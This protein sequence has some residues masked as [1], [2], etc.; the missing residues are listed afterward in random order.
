M[1][2]PPLG[3]RDMWR[4]KKTKEELEEVALAMARTWP[5]GRDI[6]GVPIFIAGDDWFID[7][8]LRRGGRAQRIEEIERELELERELKAIY[9]LAK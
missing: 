8:I 4:E 7:G 5:E 9:Q 2:S 6:T 1:L 3:L